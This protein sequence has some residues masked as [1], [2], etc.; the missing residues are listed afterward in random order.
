[1]EASDVLD[2]IREAFDGVPRP[3]TSLRQFRLTDLKG[4]A[5][6][7]TD[8]EWLEAGNHRIDGRWQDVPDAE[9]T[10]CDCVLAHMQASEFQY[11]LPA[12]MRYAIKNSHLPLWESDIL[13][14]TVSALS[15]STKDM[16]MRY[17]KR[18][19]FSLLTRAQREVIVKFLRF[20]AENA[21][22]VQRP[23]AL[24]VLERHW[25]EKVVQDG[26]DNNV[27]ILPK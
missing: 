12:Y 27:L 19:Q 6:T 15:P 23:D 26:F 21:T 8:E 7:I 1:M 16:P 22:F 25:T 4:M 17:Y 24:E 18:A 3:D 10:E 2:A 11:Y 5:G 13:G 9:I 20:V 14:L